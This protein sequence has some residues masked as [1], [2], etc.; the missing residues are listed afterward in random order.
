MI[1]HRDRPSR[2]RDAQSLAVQDVEGL[3]EGAVVQE[4]QVDI[5]DIRMTWR[6]GDPVGIPQLLVEGARCGLP[7]V[8]ERSF[9]ALRA[10]SVRS[11]GT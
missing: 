1:G 9:P 5:E 7:I 11:A 3:A 10:Y 6:R 4:V 8:H 2:P